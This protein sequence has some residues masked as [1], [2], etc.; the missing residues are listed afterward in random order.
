MY[1]RSGYK[2]SLVYSLARHGA[3]LN[4]L[5]A[6]AKTVA[7]SLLIIEDGRGCVFGAYVSEVW[8]PQSGYYGNGQTFVFSFHNH[9]IPSKSRARD[10]SKFKVYKWTHDNK[11]FQVVTETNFGVGGGGHFAIHIVRDLVCSPLLLLQ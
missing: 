4:T 2:W 9:T 10:T 6:K 11:F 5:L 8:K 7:P 1:L 3:S